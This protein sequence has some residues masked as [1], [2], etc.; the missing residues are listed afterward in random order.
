[1]TDDS[2]ERVIAIEEQRARM[3]DM[4]RHSKMAVIVGVTE[5]GSLCA[6]YMNCNPVEVLGLSKALYD[7]APHIA[8]PFEDGEE[9]DES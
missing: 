2:M 8:N 6:Y 1:M 9:L 7:M 4:L 5:D 3:Q